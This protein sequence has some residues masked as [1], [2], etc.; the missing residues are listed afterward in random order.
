MLETAVLEFM[1]GPGRE[2][3]YSTSSLL[4]PGV[5]TFWSNTQH[6]RTNQELNAF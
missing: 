3:D 6:S 1:L 4:T 5:A 2:F